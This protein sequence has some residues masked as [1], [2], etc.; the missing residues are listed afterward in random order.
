[1]LVAIAGYWGIGFP[2]A[3]PCVPPWPG[4]VGLWCGNG[5]GLVCVSLLLGARILWRLR[6]R[7]AG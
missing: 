6:A 4:G 2:G 5:I 7:Q 1:M 3:V